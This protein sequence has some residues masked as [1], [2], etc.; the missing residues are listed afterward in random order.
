[1]CAHLYDCLR[2]LLVDGYAKILCGAVEIVAES[3]VNALSIVTDNVRGHF[4]RS[5]LVPVAI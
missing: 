4:R 1:M 2:E 5:R 3:F